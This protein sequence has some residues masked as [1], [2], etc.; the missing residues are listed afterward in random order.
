MIGHGVTKTI[1]EVKGDGGGR[2]WNL[3]VGLIAVEDIGWADRGG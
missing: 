1:G 3:R 2:S